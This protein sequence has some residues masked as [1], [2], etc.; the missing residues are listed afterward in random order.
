MTLRMLKGENY[1]KRGRWEKKEGRRREG[2]EEKE[3]E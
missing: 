1:R 2:E 3:V